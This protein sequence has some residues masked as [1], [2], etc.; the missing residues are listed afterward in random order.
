MISR[1]GA[2]GAHY[3]LLHFSLLQISIIIPLS[4]RLLRPAFI[5]GRFR[6][7]QR[8]L[9]ARYFHAVPRA[10]N[11]RRRRATM[12]FDLRLSPPAAISAHDH[13]QMSAYRMAS[14]AFSTRE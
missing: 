12:I 11:Y 5:I 8:S 7:F 2:I 14:F 1:Q 9:D 6:A 13:M 10:D 3:A 4:R